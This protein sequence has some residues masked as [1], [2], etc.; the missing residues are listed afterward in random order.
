MKIVFVLLL[1]TISVSAEARVKRGFLSLP[2]APSPSDV[3]AGIRNATKVG[4]GFAG[5][6]TK[7][8]SPEVLKKILTEDWKGFQ[9]TFNKVYPTEAIAKLRQ[10][11]FA[12]NKVGIDK[13]NELFEQGKSSFAQKLNWL[14]D[15]APDEFNKLLN[16]FRAPKSK[17]PPTA[18]VRSRT[19]A[20]VPSSIDWRDV[21]AVTDVKSQ[22]LC[23]SCW[24][25]AAAGA[26]EG[27]WFRKTGK[28]V[29][30]SEQ[31]FV[32]C[33]PSDDGDGGCQTGYTDAAFEY[34]R[35][36][37][38]VNSEDAYP[39]EAKEGKCRHVNGSSVARTAGYAEVAPNEKA[40]EE[41]VGTLGPIAAAIDAS[42]TG[43]QFYSDGVYL[44]PECGNTTDDIN[45]AVLI[46]GYGQESDG[47][48][49]WI[50]KNSYGPDWGQGGYIKMAKDAGN[51][52]GIA[53]QAS[54]PLV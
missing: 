42:K 33:T 41:A 50:V 25:F 1:V 10:G 27:H 34:A 3:T 12:E 37:S 18:T 36:R 54:Y 14:G 23:Q 20:A 8:V 13:F 19:G 22:G 32:D 44:D 4:G 49:Y 16:G 17:P 30:V 21:G 24:T 6:L 53:L 39:Y 15:L 52:C 47:K 7:K 31:D 38:G 2:R 9:S 29:D 11:I 26:I 48:K 40:L 46:V 28:L 51:H 35:K 5:A 45:H 43:F